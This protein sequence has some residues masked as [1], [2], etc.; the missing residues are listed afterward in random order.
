MRRTFEFD[1]F[2]L[3]SNNDSNNAALGPSKVNAVTI[4]TWSSTDRHAATAYESGLIKIW[5]PT[6]GT[7]LNDLKVMKTE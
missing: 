1:C 4:V 3:N 5:E 6:Q 2:F 7:F